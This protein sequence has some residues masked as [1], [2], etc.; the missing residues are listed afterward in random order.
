MIRLFY[1][2]SLLQ[3]G[4]ALKSTHDRLAHP[5]LDADASFQSNE[6]SISHCFSQK[7]HMNYSF[8]G[9]VKQETRFE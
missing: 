9:N 1:F 5:S 2:W 7:F 3:E 8:V 4:R 6:P